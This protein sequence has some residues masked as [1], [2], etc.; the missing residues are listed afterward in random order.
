[1]FWWVYRKKSIDTIRY[2]TISRIVS[3]R[4]DWIFPHP[5]DSQAFVM[6]PH[7][8][9]LV[10]EQTINRILSIGQ[11]KEVSI[12]RYVMRRS[13]EEMVVHMWDKKKLSADLTL[14][15]LEPSK[16]KLTSLEYLRS[17]LE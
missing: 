14:S 13:I 11:M 3:N 8:N 7:W 5:A 1:M 6:E 9:P 2:D 12:N 4:I 17:L 10:E 16:S 15:K